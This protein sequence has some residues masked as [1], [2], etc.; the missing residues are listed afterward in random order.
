[1]TNSRVHRSNDTR[2]VGT[3]HRNSARK[4]CTL[5]KIPHILPQRARFDK[6]HQ[7][8]RPGS[9]V[10][11]A[12]KPGQIHVSHGT[13]HGITVR[14]Q[15]ERG[16]EFPGTYTLQKRFAQCGMNTDLEI[17]IRTAKATEQRRKARGEKFSHA[18]RK[19]LTRIVRRKPG[20]CFIVKRDNLLCIVEELL[21]GTC[22]VDSFSGVD[23]DRTLYRTLKLSYVLT[24]RRLSNME[25]FGSFPES[26]S[27]YYFRQRAQRVHVESPLQP[28]PPY[29]S[30]VSYYAAIT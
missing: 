27:L 20:D 1:M 21:S 8:D 5:E 2:R 22:K 19:L 24:H 17:L 13:A 6:H 12:P 16:V 14:T 15:E 7:R 10:V 9:Q 4:V 29:S 30:Q 18:Y 11:R 3:F 25:T 28:A 26:T 23:K